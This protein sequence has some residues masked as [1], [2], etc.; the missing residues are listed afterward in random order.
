MKSIKKLKIIT[1]VIL[2]SN[3]FKSDNHL[4]GYPAIQ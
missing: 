2:P 1:R 4:T 3:Q